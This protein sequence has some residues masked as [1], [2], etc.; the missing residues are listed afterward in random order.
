MKGIVIEL[1][2]VVSGSAAGPCPANSASWP[3]RT[4]EEISAAHVVSA[5]L[6]VQ[7]VMMLEI[8]AMAFEP[9]DVARIDAVLGDVGP[10]EAA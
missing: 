1:H 8:G 9:D 2:L 3:R 6:V 4:A 10:D 5:S 7:V